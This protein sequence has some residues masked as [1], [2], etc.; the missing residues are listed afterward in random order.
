MKCVS[1]WQSV[2]TT[3]ICMSGG[4]RGYYVIV[5]L[6]QNLMAALDIF[7]GCA[8]SED[9]AQIAGRSLSPRNSEAQRWCLHLISYLLR[10][11]WQSSECEIL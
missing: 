10:F 11:S 8:L 3:L 4:F 7:A 6:E 1:S 2:V 9:A 5:P